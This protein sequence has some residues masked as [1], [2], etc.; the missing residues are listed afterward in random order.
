MKKSGTGMTPPSPSRQDNERKFPLWVTALALSLAGHLILLVGVLLFT[1]HDFKKKRPFKAIDVELMKL[2]VEPP[3]AV[4]GPKKP[5]K[6]AASPT[7]KEKKK[8]KK[9]THAP[10]LSP[11]RTLEKKEK[12][13]P[14]RPPKKASMKKTE[15]K[16]VK[17]EEVLNKARAE[18]QKDLKKHKEN[19]LRKR[20]EKLAKEVE[21]ESTRKEKSP[22]ADKGE[23]GVP[24]AD[25]LDRYMNNIRI[26]VRENWAF[27]ESLAKESRDLVAVLQ[28]TVLPTGEIVDLWFEKRSGN[29]HFDRSASNAILKSNPLP[30]FPPGLSKNQQP[31]VMDFNLDDLL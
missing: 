5:K 30:P 2:P 13:S 24:S 19:A 14:A 17:P 20:F 10:V 1:G 28:F 3:L 27:P 7:K 4:S 25:L 11:K 9:K 16:V 8:N 23:R 18:L 12:H 22:A 26:T 6:K 31:V 21:S 15:K 29:G